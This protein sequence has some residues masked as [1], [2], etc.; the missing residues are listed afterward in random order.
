MG[1]VRERGVWLHPLMVGHVTHVGQWGVS[2]LGLR[3]PGL[4]PLTRRPR[5]VLPRLLV[6]D[7]M[8][9]AD[10]QLWQERAQ[11]VK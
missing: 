10:G 1:S 4:L 8:G 2:E 7:G 6:D 11:E 5:P 3:P 9:L